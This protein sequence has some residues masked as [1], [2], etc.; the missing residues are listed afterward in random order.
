MFELI[1]F[2][3][4]RERGNPGIPFLDWYELHTDKLMENWELCRKQEMPKQIEPL[5]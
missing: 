4:S 2:R 5:E 1:L 3:H